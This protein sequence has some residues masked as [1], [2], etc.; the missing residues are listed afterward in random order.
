M[1]KFT[2]FI[3]MCLLLNN[4]CN[5]S[6]Q[7][8]T[9]NDSCL[10][11]Y[12][13]EEF[14]QI[15]GVEH[16]RALDYVYTALQQAKGDGLLCNM[17]NNEI[18]SYSRLQT[19]EFFLD[20]DVDLIVNNRNRCVEFS[21]RFFNKIQTKHIPEKSANYFDILSLVESQELNKI[22]IRYLELLNEAINSDL[23]LETLIDIFQDIKERASLEL[24][25]KEMYIVL[26][27]VDIGLNS[28]AYWHSNLDLWRELLG[29]SQ[30]K[31]F[32]WRQVAAYDIAG[33]VGGAAATAITGGGI[34]AGIVGGAV[35]SSVVSATVQIICHYG[36]CD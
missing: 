28:L 13:L 21:D 32:S 35:G 5:K 16:N 3:L 6:E 7:I 23:D 31:W 26:A 25:I 8:N 2:A 17:S 34:A 27:A 9:E 15:A 19:K 4:S 18:V 30:K 33:A 24:T 14:I 11:L 20:S 10:S 22:Q 1:K 36:N 29:N 12:Q